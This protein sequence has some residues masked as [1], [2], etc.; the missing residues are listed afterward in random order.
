MSGFSRRQILSG[1]GVTA[2]A[3]GL[4]ASPALA[5][6]KEEE[7]VER[8]RLAVE[9]M[10]S[11]NNFDNLETFLKRSHGALI[12][13]SIV[14]G[15]FILGA[16]GGSGVLLSHKPGSD[17][18]YPAF[19][20]LI[21]GS[22]GLQIGAQVSQVVMTI[23]NEAALNRVLKNNV[24]LGGDASVAVGPVGKG[25][26]ASSAGALDADIVTFSSTEGAFAGVSFKGASIGSDQ[27]RN[28]YYYGKKMPAADVVLKGLASN[29][30]A[31]PLR[32]ALPL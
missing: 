17:W 23:S 13:P 16:E 10:L 8:A 21:G 2:A 3:V 12:F 19:Y 1:I 14:K 29:V 24:E 30:Q 25:V 18:S 9:S 32:K 7:L 5:L 20:T 15:G 22:I 28:G 31:D 27:D 6:T 4:G 11:S 26:G